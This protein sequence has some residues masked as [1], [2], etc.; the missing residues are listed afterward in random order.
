MLDKDVEFVTCDINR[1][2]ECFPIFDDAYGVFVVTNNWE[3]KSIGEYQQAVNIINAAKDAHV[4]HV[5][6]SVFPD[7][8]QPDPIN[9]RSRIEYYLRQLSAQSTFAYTTLIRVGYYYQNFMTFFINDGSTFEFRYPQLP[10]VQIPLYD[11]RDTGKIIVECF[12][13]PHRFGNTNDFIPIVSELLT[14]EEICFQVQQFVH[15]DIQCLELS[16]DEAFRKLNGYLVNALRWYCSNA[17]IYENQAQVTA[18]ICPNMKKI[19]DWM[20]ETKRFF[21]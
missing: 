6:F 15:R 14:M 2:E 10:Q 17:N 12:R 19:S 7:L 13:D 5:I 8:D 11:S 21:E 4:K 20:E 3:A 9:N 1:Q 18:A 16:N